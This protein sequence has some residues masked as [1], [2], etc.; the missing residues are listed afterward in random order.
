MESG[1]LLISYPDEAPLLLTRTFFG[2]FER[3]PAPAIYTVFVLIPPFRWVRVTDVGV[4][5]N[6]LH[7]PP[8]RMPL[9]PLNNVILWCNAHSLSNMLPQMDHTV[10]CNLRPL[11]ATFWFV[12]IIW[13]K[14]SQWQHW[15]C[16]A[17]S[18]LLCRAT[19]KIS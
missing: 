18:Y 1:D 16:T 15:G 7:L 6:L 17:Y 8:M 9:I 10:Y 11:R 3:R 4:E 19:S 14:L 12:S 13:L 5:R 2:Q